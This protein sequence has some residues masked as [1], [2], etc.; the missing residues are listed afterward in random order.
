MAHQIIP[1]F[2]SSESGQ[3]PLFVLGVSSAM[4]ALER[5]IANVAHIDIP[6]LLVGESGSGKEI[7]ALEIHRRSR[8]ADEPFTKWG[9]SGLSP[10]FLKARMQSSEA[11]TGAALS[12]NGTLFLDEIGILDRASQ[13][14]LVHLLPDTSRISLE[15]PMDARVI[16]ST[17]KNLDEEIRAGRFHEGLYYRVNG[18]CLKIPPLRERKDDIPALLDFFLTKYT[19]LFGRPQPEMAPDTVDLLACHNWPG[20]VRELENV[21]RKIVAFGHDR[22]L[23]QDFAAMDVAVVKPSRA[24]A[25]VPAEAPRRPI[26]TA[27]TVQSLREASREAARNAEREL[28]LKHLER[29]HWNRKRTARELQISYKALLYKLKLLGLEG[30]NDSDEEQ[31]G[32]GK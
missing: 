1:T 31:S 5:T 16:S 26:G 9:C 29:T 15:K 3:I 17:T 4:S 13:D 12:R 6:I 24:K 2:T 14:R 20:N 30:S 8:H 19:A 23:A 11:M 7:V 32:D 22:V 21:A 28:I 27:K 18:V 10:E 25:I